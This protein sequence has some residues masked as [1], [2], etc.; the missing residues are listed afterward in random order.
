MLCVLIRIAHRGHSTYNHCVKIEKIF[1]N[2]RYLPW[3]TLSGSNYPC[4]ERISKV[5]KIF[6]PL[7]FDCTFFQKGKAP[8]GL[9]DVSFFIFFF[10]FFF[11]FQY[12][13]EKVCACAE[14]ADGLLWACTYWPYAER[15]DSYHIAHA[16]ILI[17]HPI[18]SDDSVTW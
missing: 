12:A 14:R 7:R 17:I 18:V 3:S 13:F 8:C 15:A 2:Y 5:P 9:Y 1:L 10:L 16:H 11:L 4:L 6:E